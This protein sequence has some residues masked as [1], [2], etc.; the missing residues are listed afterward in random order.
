M[1]DRDAMLNI[2]LKADWQHTKERKQHHIP[3]NNKAEN[4]KR[5]DHT[6]HPLDEAMAVVDPSCKLEGQQFIGP[7]TVTQVH[8]NGTVQLSQAT[9]GGAVSRTWNICQL[10]PC[11]ART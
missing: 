5:K 6:C 10:R 9:H 7:C 4:A 3:Q 11:W 1:F 8:D 2:L